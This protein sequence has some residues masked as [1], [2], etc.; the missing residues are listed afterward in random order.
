MADTGEVLRLL[1]LGNTRTKLM[2]IAGNA[3]G[4]LIAAAESKI[5]T[6]AYPHSVSATFLQ[7]NLNATPENAWKTMLELKNICDKS[8]KA[9]RVYITIAFGNPYGEAS[10]DEIVIGE[11]E[12][13][14]SAGIRELVVSDTTGEGTPESIE[15]L[16]TK[17]ISFFP[18]EKLGIHLHTKPDDW[19]K[20]IDAAWHAGI[21]RFESA[22]GG[23]GGCPMTGHEL[24]AN[25]NTLDLAGWFSRKNIDSGIDENALREA[26]KIA[27]KVFN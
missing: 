5:H 7:R 16:C 8:A 4:G 23:F 11:V 14:Y 13:L 20:K 21:R 26:Q 12:K 17:I 9:L 19:K 10:N 25:L 27:V 1:D 15:R 3:R 2:V 18:D 22:L 24:L 6:I